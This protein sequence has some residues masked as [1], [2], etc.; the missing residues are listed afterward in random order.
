MLYLLLTVQMCSFAHCSIVCGACE[1]DRVTGESAILIVA[2][3]CVCVCMCVCERERERERQD[4]IT[5]E[6]TAHQQSS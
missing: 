1:R 5:A 2:C 6:C 3:V 4:H